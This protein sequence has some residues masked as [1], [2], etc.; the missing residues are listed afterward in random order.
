MAASMAQLLS[1]AEP[2]FPILQQ[3]PAAAD[4]VYPSFFAYYHVLQRKSVM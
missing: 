3:P 4:Q 1:T 2:V